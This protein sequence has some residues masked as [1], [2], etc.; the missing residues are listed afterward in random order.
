V[1]RER[2][3]VNSFIYKLRKRPDFI[4]SCFFSRDAIM[5]ANYRRLLVNISSNLSSEDLANLIFCCEEFITEAKAEKISNGIELFKALRHSDLL[6]PEKYEYLR[7]QL[8]VV[9]RSDLASLLPTPLETVLSSIPSDRISILV[10]NPSGDG[11]PS[12]S[13]AASS[14]ATNLKFLTLAP[15]SQFLRICDSLTEDNVSK[16]SFLF[17]D[18]LSLRKKTDEIK[19]PLELFLC[20][21][22]IGVI[23]VECLESLVEPLEEIGRKDLAS[24]LPSQIPISSLPSFL[25]SSQ[26]L[27]EVKISMFKGRQSDYSMQRKILRT[28]ATCDSKSLNGHL[29]VPVVNKLISLYDYTLAFKLSEQ[30]R[31]A[32][33]QSKNLTGTLCSTLQNVYCFFEVY[34]ECIFQ[35]LQSSEIDLED[36]GS[37]FK[38]CHQH[39]SRFE[40]SMSEMNWKLDLI[41]VVRNDFTERRTPIGTPA[42]KAV[43]C[44]YEVCS[45]LYGTSEI[46]KIMEKVDSNLYALESLHYGYC[47]RV[48]ITQWVETLIFLLHQADISISIVQATLLEILRKSLISVNC[49]YMSL[50]HIVGQVV[51]DELRE[52]L[53]SKGIEVNEKNPRVTSGRFGNNYVMIWSLSCYTY[54]VL[55]LYIAFFGCEKLDLHGIFNRLKLHVNGFM[56]TDELYITSTITIL[57]K[58]LKSFESQID[59]FREKAIKMNPLC[60]QAIDSIIRTM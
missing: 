6:G 7:E 18:K 5:A 19:G 51:L 11:T 15:R 56:T 36:L 53:Q 35:T 42:L 45:E 60:S 41:G 20:L 34:F 46:E 39:Y 57:R 58:A 31:V 47:W 37:R 40:A 12:S 8:V 10:E 26:Q 55:L 29:V 54:L 59:G 17:A 38:I 2:R 25:N 13:L 50:R 16:L 22:Q 9:G 21:E 27:L 30:S 33:Q 43:K 48:T 49:L 14:P 32:V 3:G 23:N 24:L 28:I 52:L 1:V 4:S 44:I